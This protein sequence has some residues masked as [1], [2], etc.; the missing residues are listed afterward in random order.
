MSGLFSDQAV[1]D[2][3]EAS[4]TD[5]LLRLINDRCRT[6]AWDQLIRLRVLLADAVTRGKQLWGV[7]EHIRYRL[8]LEGPPE[9]A[10]QAVIE[11]PARFALGPLTEVAANRHSFAD[12]VP[13]LAAGPEKT[14]VAHE[15]VLAGE[16][17][18]PSQI[19]PHVLE[20]PSRLLEWEPGYSR[21]AYKADRVE[22][23][24]PPLPVLT[25]AKLPDH[26]EE[27]DDVETITALLGL[28]TPWIEESNGRGQAV[29]AYGGAAAAIRLIGPARA[30]VGALSPATAL[31]WMAWAAAS[32]G[33]MGRRRGGAAGRV[34]AWWALSARAGR[35]WPAAGEAVG[36]ALDKMRWFSGSD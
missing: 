23:H 14:L 5:A 1:V 31:A 18:D 25:E 22:S 35:D 3:I 10:A 33:A 36:N 7:D 32:G 30:R 27:V 15:R 9:L 21:P 16:S 4:D 11:G 34:S 17:I 28:V 6:R 26:G 19:D 12:L 8:A 13:H 29:C 20:L 24:P 2:A